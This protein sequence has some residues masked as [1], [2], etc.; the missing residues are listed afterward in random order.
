MTGAITAA[1]GAWNAAIVAEIVKFGGTTLTATGLGA[2]IADAT[3]DGD[4]PRILVG[5]L[6]MSVFVVG[7]NRLF[8]RRLYALAQRRYSL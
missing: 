1:G 8:W 7:T 3:R 2:Y 6:A 4:W 5:V